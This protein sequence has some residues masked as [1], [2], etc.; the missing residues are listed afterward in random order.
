MS[1]KVK[2]I[3]VGPT[4][5]SSTIDV[6]AA[7]NCYVHC[8]QYH[9][10][11]SLFVKMQVKIDKRDSKEVPNILRAL[12]ERLTNFT[13]EY[14]FWRLPIRGWYLLAL[15]SLFSFILDSKPTVSSST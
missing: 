4:F 3:R 12:I 10:L 5:I 14:D 2:Q 11:L 15:R 7:S 13:V 1:L 8:F 6:V 9:V